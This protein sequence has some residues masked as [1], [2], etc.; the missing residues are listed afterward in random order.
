VQWL[1]YRFQCNGRP[2]AMAHLAGKL[3]AD[4]LAAFWDDWT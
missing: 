4:L 1:R 3:K 2:E